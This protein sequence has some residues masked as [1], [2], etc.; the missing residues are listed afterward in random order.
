ME[1]KTNYKLVGLW[2]LILITG[3]ITTALWLSTGFDK[4]SYTFYTVYA[5]EPV[6]GL[7]EESLVKF[8]G[9]KVGF[10]NKIEINRSNPQLV[11]L[12]LKIVADTPI[13][14]S[15]YASLILQGITGSTYLGLTVDGPDT[16]P[17][18]KIPT[19]PYPVIPFK[20]SFL[21]QLEMN[22]NKVSTNLQRVFDKKN[23]TNLQKTLDHLE[24]ITHVI[25]ESDADIYKS[26][27]EL[28]SVMRELKL[29][30][31]QFKLMAD[32][33]SVASKQVTSTMKTAKNGIEQI[34]QQVVPTTTQILRRIDLI[35]T[36]L[37]VVSEKIKENPSAIIRGTTPNAPGP[38]ESR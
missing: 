26:L 16:T 28:P 24:K 27:R 25:A 34:S 32:H 2:V 35:A 6:T 4:R 8:N 17:L 5:N 37:E 29:G 9:V 20:P 36:N 22:I 12:L 30:M 11:K 15:T 7:S 21:R 10:V 18:P 33:L 38:G 3:L 23:A 31:Q 1:S 13:T 19:D 14:N